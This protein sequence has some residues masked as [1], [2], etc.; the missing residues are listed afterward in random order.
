MDRYIFTEHALF[1]MQRRGLSKETVEEVIK[2]P[3]QQWY[4]KK[5]RVVLQSRLFVAASEKLYL[6]RVFVDLDRNP[7]EVVTA[8]KTSKIEKYWR[9]EP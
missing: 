6:V 1:E 3:E 5:G 7:P 9:E 4:V 8:Y 2:S